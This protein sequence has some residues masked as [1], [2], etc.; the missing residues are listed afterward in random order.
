MNDDDR[1]KQDT[2]IFIIAVIY[3]VAIWYLLTYEGR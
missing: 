1:N 2:I 3:V